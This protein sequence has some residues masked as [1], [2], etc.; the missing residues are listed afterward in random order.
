M[1][2][3]VV[4]DMAIKAGHSTT[5]TIL[6]NS[7]S[8]VITCNAVVGNISPD[9][10]DF[11]QPN[12]NAQFNRVNTNGLNSAGGVNANYSVFINNLGNPLIPNLSLYL[13]DQNGAVALYNSSSTRYEW[14]LDP[15]G[16]IT[17]EGNIQVDGYISDTKPFFIA[18]NYTVPNDGRKYSYFV[19]AQPVGANPLSIVL[20]LD[21]PISQE[22]DLILSNAGTASIISVGTSSPALQF[23][24]MGGTSNSINLL[25]AGPG[26]TSTLNRWLKLKFVNYGVA[27]DWWLWS[28]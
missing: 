9:P 11:I 16:N 3:T 28:V 18:G 12:V 2:Y 13:G 8:G 25:N 6:F 4:G 14:R 17:A 24:G 26:G 27:G 10:L 23:M 20:P 7:L 21:P 19:N 1:A 15:G 22:I 5:P